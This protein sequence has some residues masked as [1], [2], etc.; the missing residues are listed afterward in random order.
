MEWDYGAYEGRTT[1]QVREELPGWTIWTGGSERG[2]GRSSVRGR[3]VVWQAGAISRVV[4]SG[5]G[6][7]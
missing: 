6:G 3:G 2:T 1:G 4:G 7:W 5:V